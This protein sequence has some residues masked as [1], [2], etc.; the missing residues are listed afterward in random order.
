[1]FKKKLTLFVFLFS[2]IINISFI[3]VKSFCNQEQ[4]EYIENILNNFEKGTWEIVEELEPGDYSSQIYLVRYVSE[5]YIPKYYVFKIL[6]QGDTKTYKRE[7]LA[8]EKF[9][10]YINDEKI[11]E[12]I[13][14]PLECGEL[15]DGF[16]YVI[17][18]YA[19]STNNEN[20][21]NHMNFLDS[22]GIEK[23]PFNE[24]ATIWNDLLS[25]KLKAIEFLNKNNILHRD[26]HSGNWKIAFYRKDNYKYKL[27]VK[28]IDFG[29]TVDVSDYSPDAK[30]MYYPN[31]KDFYPKD[32]IANHDLICFLDG[33]KDDAKCFLYENNIINKIQELIDYLKDGHICRRK[34][35]F[36]YSHSLT[37]KQRLNILGQ[38]YD[39]LCLP[40]NLNTETVSKSNQILKNEKNLEWL[41]SKINGIT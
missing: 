27:K 5:D 25:Q 7:K 26:A 17:Y 40:T 34:K 30:P 2:F 3:N 22:Y 37:L 32:S 20:L 10:P 19:E 18:K 14:P 39:W 24:V 29:S 15:D 1:M 4:S 38:L 35:Y 8:C 11:T 23:R 13:C 9:K 21:Y 12:N 41:L 6:L 16:Y 36:K 28:L 31:N 33:L